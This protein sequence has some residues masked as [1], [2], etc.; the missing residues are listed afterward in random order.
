MN[1]LWV[2]ARIEGQAFINDYTRSLC[3]WFEE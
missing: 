2:Y 1:K 3:E